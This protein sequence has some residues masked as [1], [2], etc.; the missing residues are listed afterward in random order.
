LISTLRTGFAQFGVHRTIAVGDTRFALNLLR[1]L[2]GTHDGRVVVFDR[3]RSADRRSGCEQPSQ[4]LPLLLRLLFRNCVSLPDL[5]NAVVDR[6]DQLWDA[7]RETFLAREMVSG[8]TLSS[9]EAL[10]IDRPW[11]YWLPPTGIVR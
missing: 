5:E 10:P 6:F 11:E 1:R 9:L 4:L 8:L 2:A 7:A 3:R